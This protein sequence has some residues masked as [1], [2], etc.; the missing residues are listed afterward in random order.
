MGNQAFA[1][2]YRWIQQHSRDLARPTLG[3]P[4]SKVGTAAHAIEPFANG[5]LRDHHRVLIFI[6]RESV[7]P[8]RHHIFDLHSGESAKIIV[9]ESHSEAYC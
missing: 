9:V 8:T 4:A 7:F 6:V 5:A 1:K 3:H 2:F